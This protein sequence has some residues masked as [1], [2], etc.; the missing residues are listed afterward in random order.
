MIHQVC[1]Q[2]MLYGMHNERFAQERLN[3]LARNSFTAAAGW[4]ECCY[5]QLIGNSIKY[6]FCLLFQ[7]LQFTFGNK[8]VNISLFGGH[9]VLVCFFNDPGILEAF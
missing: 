5:D 1:F 7:Q 8:G 6:R 9:I 2:S 3:I 4:N